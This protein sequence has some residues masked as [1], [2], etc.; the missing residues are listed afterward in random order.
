MMKREELIKKWLDHD[1]SE[2]ELIAFEQLDDYEDIIKLNTTLKLFKAPNFNKD[3]SYSDYKS[4]LDQKFSMKWQTFLPRIAAVLAI[5]FAVYY[6]TSTLDTEINTR[7]AQQT[8]LELP[9]A[10]HIDLNSNSLLIFNESRW[11]NNRE[12]QLDGEAFFKV[13][14]GQQFDVITKNGIVTVLG[15][16][17]NVKQRDNYFEVTCYEGLVSVDTQSK[18]HKL[19]PGTTLKFIDNELSINQQQTS[20]YPTWLDGESSFNNV[21]LKHVI[22]ELQS[23]YNIEIFIDHIDALRKFTGSFT[24][25]DLDLALKSVT[26]PLNL[27]YKKSGNSIVIKRE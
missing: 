15:T 10:S 7:I 12:V 14:K 23:Q 13:A 2:Q 22:A 25:K 5:C 24:H 18:K 26:I 27:N 9:D 1:L 20:N 16:Q 19:S 11:E 3:D 21:T 17:F 4:K 8:Q 6:Y